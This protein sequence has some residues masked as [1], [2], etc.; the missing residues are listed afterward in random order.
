MKIIPWIASAILLLTTGILNA[1]DYFQQEVDYAIQV[2]LDDQTHFLRGFEK[3]EYTNNSPGKLTEIYFHLPPNAYKNNQTY[4]AREQFRREGK[5]YL[6]S[7]YS[8]SGFIDSLNFKVNNENVDWDYHKEHIDICRL[9]LNEPLEPGETLTITTPFRLKIPLAV[10]S[11]LG[12]VDQSYKIS[13]WFPKPAVYNNEGWHKNPY[14]DLGKSYSE[15]GS[16]DVSITL[17]ENYVVAAPGQL[18]TESEKERIDQIEKK[19]SQKLGFNAEDMEIPESSREF[20][21]IRYKIDSVTDFVWFADKRYHVLTNEISL[22]NSEKTITTRTFFTNEQ[23]DLWQNANKYISQALKNYSK[24]FGNYMYDNFTAVVGAPGSD[25]NNEGYPAITCTKFSETN[26]QLEQSI[27][28]GL[29][30]SWYSGMLNFNPK[31][32]PFLPEGL[33]K[34]SEIRYLKDKYDNDNK[35]HKYYNINDNVA[36]VLGI[37]DLDYSEELEQMH[38]FIARKNRDQPT[39][40]SMEDI[41]WTNYFAIT[42]AKTAKAFQHLS[43]YLGKN[44]FDRLMQDFFS[45]WKYKH[46]KPRDLER[47]FQ[48]QAG[49]DLNWFFD[50]MLKTNE[51]SDYAILKYR[52]NKVLIKNKGTIAA[53]LIIKGIQEGETQFSK[54]YEGFEGKKWL[55]I[56]SGSPEKIVIDPDRVMLELYRT[57]NTLKTKGLFKRTEPLKLQFA[58]LFSNPQYT[59]LNYLP[60][61]AWNSYDKLMIG[62]LSYDPPLPPDKFDYFLSPLYSIGTNNFGGKGYA[63]FNMYPNHLFQQIQMKVSG[64]RFGY[65]N[66]Y[67]ESYNQLQGG[68]NF[69][70]SNNQDASPGGNKI[71]LK[72]TYATDIVDILDRIH[73]EE[74]QSLAYN[75]FLEASFIHDY[76]DKNINPYSLQAGVEWSERFTKTSFEA[77]YKYSYY[78]EEGLSVSL[79]GGMFLNKNENLPWNYAFHLSGGNGWQ[80]YKYEHT[81]LGRFEGPLDENANQLYVQQY[82]PE[83]GGFTVYSPLGSTKDWLLSLNVASVLPIINALPIHAYANAGAFGDSRSIPDKEISNKTWA[84]E[85]GIKFSFLN[86]VDIYFPVFTS[87]NL[88]KASQYITNRYG[89]KIR[90]HVKFDLLNSRNLSKE[91][92]SLY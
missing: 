6:F 84:Y 59:E 1:Q 72:S 62:M 2:E 78:M 26:R 77:N 39:N 76:S 70:F 54:W 57:N 71:K 37:T 40:T 60:A 44:Q 38:Y 46:P 33:A 23:A 36:D 20:K 56:P 92:K 83:E 49:K 27:I 4:L 34:Y 3:I 52:N 88:K 47:V 86:A 21:T 32:Y 66:Y 68:L 79:F 8:Q 10:T 18:V 5:H 42:K 13:Q 41:T 61:L 35:L 53:P 80:D 16:F 17:P 19:T 11:R 75:H 67:N 22:P 73:G 31:S 43:E 45:E 9:K 7:V 55:D 82:Y 25:G 91:I 28:Q 87:K 24:W 15:Y 69:K 50:K 85:G 14:R 63:A 30:H 51:K 90:F 89:E 12:Y 58:G 81:F 74:K 65:S 64:K 29:S 48:R